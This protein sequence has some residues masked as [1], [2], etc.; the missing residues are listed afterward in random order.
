MH[1][2]QK[3][4]VTISRADTHLWVEELHHRTCKLRSLVMHPSEFDFTSTF[5]PPYA[6]ARRNELDRVLPP[7]IKD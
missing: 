7:A 2:V 5:E 4:A 1:G 6:G 3:Y